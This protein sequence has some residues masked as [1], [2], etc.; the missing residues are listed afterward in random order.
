MRVILIRHGPAAARDARRWPDDARR[1][2]TARGA[3]RTE[4]ALRG[5]KHEY[6]PTRICS[7]PLV[8]CTETA[9]IA[10][11]VFTAA[12]A[13]ETLAA[14]APSGSYTRIVEFLAQ[15][16]P[17]ESVALVGH[18]PDLGKLAGVLVFGAPATT[19]PLKKAGV[20]VIDF[21]GKVEA[22]KGHLLAFLPPRVLRARTGAKASRIGSK[23]RA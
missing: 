4:R 23:A 19:L 22:G 9:A 6:V 15:C 1:P 16:K 8:R 18:E 10:Q 17:S 14:L 21:A 11:R 5:L 3:E 20:C 12:R 2:L 7:S 13:P